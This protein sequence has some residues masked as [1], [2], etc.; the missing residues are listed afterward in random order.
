MW[1][2]LSTPVAQTVLWLAGLAVLVA[3]GVYL[4]GRVRPDQQPAAQ[5]ASELLSEFRE[6]Y[7]QGELSDEEFRTIKSKLNQRLQQ[8]LNDNGQA[9]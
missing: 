8:E 6:L 1:D 7:E 4:V 3:A 5:S 9:G 2:Y